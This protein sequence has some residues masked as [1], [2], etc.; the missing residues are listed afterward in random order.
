MF[1][2]NL[3]AHLRGIQVA[4]QRIYLALEEYNA[5]NIKP[6]DN[7]I[8]VAENKKSK[9]NAVVKV[10]KVAPVARRGRKC[11]YGPDF[12]ASSTCFREAGWD[13]EEAKVLRSICDKLGVKLYVF[14]NN[15]NYYIRAL[16]FDM[17]VSELSQMD[18][19]VIKSGVQY[20][21]RV[22]DIK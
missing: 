1:F 2:E 17:V 13:H 20:V 8:R 14:N 6:V 12:C 22:R 5:Q 11:K 9:N 15:H 4:L 10:D 16:D 3:Y 21:N 19:K 18:G 7:N